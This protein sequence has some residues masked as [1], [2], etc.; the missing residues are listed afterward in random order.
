MELCN[1][2]LIDLEAD[3]RKSERVTLVTSGRRSVH[4]ARVGWMSHVHSSFLPSSV[5]ISALSTVLYS[6]SFCI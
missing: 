6:E 4:R 1:F 2:E 3:S 5:Y